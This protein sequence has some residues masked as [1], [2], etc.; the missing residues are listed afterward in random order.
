MSKRKDYPVIRSCLQNI[1]FSE[2]H[3]WE[4]KQS[5]SVDD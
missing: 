2:I 4:K 5:F 3:R 1:H